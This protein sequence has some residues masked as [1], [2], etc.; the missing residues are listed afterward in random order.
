MTATKIKGIINEQGELIIHEK[1]NLTPGEVEV[2]ILNSV[3][4]INPDFE[5]TLKRLLEL[6]EIDPDLPEDDDDEIHYPSDYAFNGSM[7]L[8]NQLYQILG[9]NF[10]RGYASVESRGGVYLIWNNQ[11]LDKQV[12]FK[13]PVDLNFTSSVYYRHGDHSKLIQQPNVILITKILQ[14]LVTENLT[15]DDY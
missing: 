11:Q 7:E 13:F 15:I 3:T 4:T 12:R 6:K 2:F 9:S 1:L 8:L 5:I 14:W 10:P